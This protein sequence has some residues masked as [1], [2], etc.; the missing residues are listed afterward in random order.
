MA[1]VIEQ[2]SDWVI[3]TSD[4][5]RNENPKS[6]IDEIILGFSKDYDYIVEIERREAIEKAIK[7]AKADDIILIAGKG[8]ESYQIIGNNRYP[9]DDVEIAKNICNTI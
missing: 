3:V 8:H 9:F 6:I 5:P 1:Q 2:L 4:N 7:M